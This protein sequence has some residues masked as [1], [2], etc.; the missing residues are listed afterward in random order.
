MDQPSNQ[1]HSDISHNECDGDKITPEEKTETRD[2]S[3]MDIGLNDHPDFH[4]T[5]FY[6]LQVQSTVTYFIDRTCRVADVNQ[7][8]S[9]LYRS[10]LFY[11][12]SSK[13]CNNSL[14]NHSIIHLSS[15]ILTHTFT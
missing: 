7:N 1:T 4:I 3:V 2:G 10:L 6:A 15:R 13:E 14:L 12:S 11:L 8:K 5:L 9:A